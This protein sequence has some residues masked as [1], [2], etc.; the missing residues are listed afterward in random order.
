MC[1]I[2]ESYH[3]VFGVEPLQCLGMTSY[4]A[5]AHGSIAVTL[6]ACVA[7]RCEPPPPTPTV[8]RA[9]ESVDPA[10]ERADDCR[11]DIPDCSAACALRE[12][13]HLEFIDWFDRRCAAVMLGKNPDKTAGAEPPVTPRGK[14]CDPAF[15][16]DAQ[17]IKTW[18]RDCL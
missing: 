15:S 9:A 10:L 11:R 2:R 5:G 1:F 18:K 8:P 13:K 16:L 14:D 7:L 12:T 4:R 17:G 6:V 3:D